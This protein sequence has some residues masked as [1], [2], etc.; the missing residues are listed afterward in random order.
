M[1]EN[2]ET[3][4]PFI[5]S[6][7][8]PYPTSTGLPGSAGVG[9]SP[10]NLTPLATTPISILGWSSQP[11]QPQYTT[12]VGDASVPSQIAALVPGAD[13]AL[14]GPGPNASTGIGHGHTGHEA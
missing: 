12:D 11:P 13:Q 4:V 9:T 10:E 7:A 3:R 5:V 14:V 1:A 2:A 8:I 6:P